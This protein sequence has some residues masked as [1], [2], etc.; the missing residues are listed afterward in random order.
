MHG[1]VATVAV[2]L[3]MEAVFTPSEDGSVKLVN[4]RPADAEPGG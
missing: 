2:G 4:W 1:D 3:P